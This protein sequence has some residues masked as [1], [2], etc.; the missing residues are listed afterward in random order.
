MAEAALRSGRVTPAGEEPRRARTISVVRALATAVILATALAG[1]APTADAAPAAGSTSEIALPQQGAA[2]DYQLGG[3]Y[4]PPA[5]VT[6]VARD[7]TAVASGVGYDICYVNGF[8]TQPAESEVFARERPELVLLSDGAP[9]IDPGWPDEYLFD[10]SA[11]QKR[12]ALLEIVGEWIRGCAAS[13]YD[14]V[15]IDNLDSYTRS[16]GALTAQD[17]LDLAAAYARAAHDAGLAIAQKNTADLTERV[18]GVGY[19]FAVTE[20]CVRFEEC[21]AYISVY[22]VVLDIEYTDELGER[23]F[24]EAC[25]DT[26]RA[27]SMI[28]RDHDLVA[29]DD[30]AYVFRTCDAG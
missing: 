5:G 22:P 16:G 14:A 12:A 21:G 1:C 18:R 8:Q 29:P 25:D 26:G 28:L 23:G 4:D 19:D 2:F 20:S 15:E 27:A 9:L 11:P 30:E 13:G 7:R 24:A 3:A 17:N 6:V 10:T